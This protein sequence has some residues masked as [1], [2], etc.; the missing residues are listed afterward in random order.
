[1]NINYRFSNIVLKTVYIHSVVYVYCDGN[2]LILR[3]TGYGLLVQCSIL[4]INETDADV[5]PNFYDAREYVDSCI[6]F[7][8][9]W[10]SRVL[11]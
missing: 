3:G 8:R 7:T 2:R 9:N 11:I 10:V 6:R 1:M 5:A 4:E